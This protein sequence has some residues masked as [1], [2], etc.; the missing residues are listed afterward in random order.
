MAG[1]AKTMK[2]V[3][4]N[5][6]HIAYVG[7]DGRGIPTDIH[8]T[9]GKTA[10]E[11]ILTVLHAGGKFDQ[12]NYQ[13]S[14]GL[15]GVGASVVNALS[16]KMQVWVL[17]GGKIHYLSFSKGKVIGEMEVFDEELLAGRFPETIGKTC[18]KKTGT[19]TSFVPDNTIFETVDFNL[20]EINESLKQTA[21][22]NKGLKIS[23]EADGEVVEDYTQELEE[24]KDEELLALFTA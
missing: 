24:I 18:W 23:F 16:I 8:P 22:L 19:L 10:L 17:R 13:F 11:T 9:T 12:K 6:N 3:I 1:H 14:G 4:D 5:Q 21:Y 7:D 2:V 15:H 20:K